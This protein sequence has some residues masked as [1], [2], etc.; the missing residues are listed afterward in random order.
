VALNNKVQI[1]EQC[2]SDFMSF[3]ALVAPYLDFGSIH[4]E[5]GRWLTRQDASDNLMLLLPRG[6]LKSKLAAL[7]AAW[8]ITKDPTET[9]LYVSATAALAEAQLSQ[10]KQIFESSIHRRYWPEMINM[11]EG[12]REKWTMSEISVDHPIRRKEGIR[13]QTVRAVGLTANTTGFHSSKTILDDVVVPRNAYTEEG[14][15]KV[16]QFYSQLASIENPE[17][18][19]V[20]V[21]TRYHPKDLYQ[22]L[23]DM[24]ESVYDVEEKEWVDKP[25]FEVF[26]RVV[27]TNG[28]FLWP[29]KARE[30]GKRFGFDEQTLARIKAKYTG[31]ITQFYCQYYQKPN[32]AGSDVVDRNTFQYYDRKHLKQEEGYWF[33]KEEKLNVFA[34]IDFAFSLKKKADYTSIVV[35]GVTS[36]HN[37]YVLD[38][39]RF[40]TDRIKDYFDRI[41]QAHC[42]WGFRKIRAEVTTAQQAIVSE[43]KESYIKP[44]GLSLS[45]DE[46]RPNRHEGDKAERI[47]AILAPKYDNFQI[48]HYNG[49]N[50]QMLEEE[51]VMQHPAH[52]DLKEGLANAVAISKAPSKRIANN[53]FHLGAIKYNPRFG[54]VV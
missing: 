10:I 45:V 5:A 20:V 41:Y 36:E 53:V 22:T 34:A 42:K 13:D 18:K 14:R 49:G 51:L 1:R 16:S 47:E 4:Y 37:Y 43:I 27:E 52:D 54:G 15:H 25:V 32:H 30:D 3:C 38:L 28:D 40:K 19:Q 46:Y 35:V 6:H 23:L 17:A 11:D 33:F 7:L 24:S 39:D 31:D 44:M 29:R 2:E 8:W 50:T 12:K 48:W 21:G 9:I 26:T